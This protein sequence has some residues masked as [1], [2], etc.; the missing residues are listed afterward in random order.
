MP[1]QRSALAALVTIGLLLTCGGVLARPAPA[2]ISPSSLV[3]GVVSIR[4]DTRQTLIG[5]EARSAYG[6]TGHIR[7]GGTRGT[8]QL[9]GSGAVIITAA[10]VLYDDAGRLRADACV[11]EVMTP[12]GLQRV[13]VRLDTVICG[14]KQPLSSPATRDWAVVALERGVTGIQP[15]RI[16]GSTVSG[17]DVT[18]VS[19]RRLGQ[20]GWTVQ[21]CKVH[22]RVDGAPAEIQ[23]DCSA[24]QG[25]SGAAVLTPSGKLAALYVGYRSAAPRRSQPYSD[26]HY[27]FAITIDGPI[28]SAV[29][30]LDRRR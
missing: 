23:L 18:M 16:G 6:A 7:C 19:G 15:Y 30:R 4:P 25:D 28:H 24:E 22:R 8:A 14:S 27:N 2:L 5:P 11:F 26:R 1:D 29:R 17:T 10:H 13:H 21:T 3:T 20:R 12:S 9:V